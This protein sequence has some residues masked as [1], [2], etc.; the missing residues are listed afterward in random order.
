MHQRSAVASLYRYHLLDFPL[1]EV[2]HAGLQGHPFLLAWQKKKKHPHQWSHPNVI[3]RIHKSP[4]EQ[5]GFWRLKLCVHV[6]SPARSPASLH[7]VHPNHRQEKNAPSQNRV[8]SLQ[9]HSKATII[10]QGL[11]GTFSKNKMA[12][13]SLNSSRLVYIDF[14]VTLLWKW[15]TEA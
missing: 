3:H 2:Y 6:V 1:W 13:L 8:K 12:E 14:V 10:Y 15:A 9:K 5:L 11:R 4:R 7:P